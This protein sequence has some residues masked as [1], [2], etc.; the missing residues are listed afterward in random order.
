MLIIGILNLVIL[1]YIALNVV[2]SLNFL[3]KIAGD[4]SSIQD[5]CS[6]EHAKVVA[7]DMKKKGYVMTEAGKELLRANTGK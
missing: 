2:C 5:Y 7:E 6:K 1:I 4:I 3:I